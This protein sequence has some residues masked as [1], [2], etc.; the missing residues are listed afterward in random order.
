MDIK[1]GAEVGSVKVHL[2][3]NQLVAINLGNRLINTFREGHDL[4]T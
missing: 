4:S 3:V 1:K 2:S